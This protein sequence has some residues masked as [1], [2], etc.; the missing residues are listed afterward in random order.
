MMGSEEKTLRK[1]NFGLKPSQNLFFWGGVVV[2][3]CY[4]SFGEYVYIYIDYIEIYLRRMIRVLSAGGMKSN[5]IFLETKTGQY[6]S[7]V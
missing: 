1:S 7:E 6:L 5:T 2:V 4:Q 3:F